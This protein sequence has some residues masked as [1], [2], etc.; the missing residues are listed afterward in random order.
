MVSGKM[1]ARLIV[2]SSAWVALMGVLLFWPAGN[3][4]WPQGW[5]FLGI[6]SLG[7][8]V[9]CIWLLKRDP[10]LLAARMGSPVQKDQPLWDRVFMIG[11]VLSWNAWLVLMALDAQRWRISHMPV[12]LDV[13]GGLLVVLGFAAVM[14]VFAANSFAA[15]VVKIQNERGQHVIDSGPYAIVRHPMYAS[16]TI[17]LIGMPLLLGSWIGLAILPVLI[18]L[19][20]LRIPREERL[21]RA[22][23]AGYEAYAARVRWRLVPY[24][25]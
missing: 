23:L 15:P 20:S 6:F 2:Q 11:A 5:A 12:W 8:A 14:P 13:V 21:L 1:L 10:A 18:V 17:Y 9:F 16:A 25:W 24:L 7:T 3:W 19:L 22:E 4:R